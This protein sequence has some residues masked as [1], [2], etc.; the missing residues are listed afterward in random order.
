MKKNTDNLAP[1]HHPLLPGRPFLMAYKS[2]SGKSGY[3]RWTDGLLCAF[4]SNVLSFMFKEHRLYERLME[5]VPRSEL[6][7][8][9]VLHGGDV[10]GWWDRCPAEKIDSI[11]GEVRK[12]QTLALEAAAL[13]PQTV[14]DHFGEWCNLKQDELDS[15]RSAIR[16]HAP[17]T[18]PN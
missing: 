8:G 4:Q 14:Q 18:L 5:L 9:S 17:R 11:V 6:P 12:V 15:L 16:E 3:V 1:D 13:L 7:H 10:C 2:K